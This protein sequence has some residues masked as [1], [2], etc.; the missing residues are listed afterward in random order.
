MVA[1]AWLIRF[2]VS[3]SRKCQLEAYPLGSVDGRQSVQVCHGK[4]NPLPLQF[5]IYVHHTSEVRT[6]PKGICP[7]LGGER[8]AHEEAALTYAALRLARHS[9]PF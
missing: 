4:F 3:F 2:A 6:A 9:G 5:L 1:A 8:K 7:C